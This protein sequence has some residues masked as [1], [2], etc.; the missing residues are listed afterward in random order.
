MFN[1][2][3]C[4]SQRQKENDL[5]LPYIVLLNYKINWIRPM[6]WFVRILTSVLSF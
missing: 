1:I 4:G 2:L 5:Y 6:V 3:P